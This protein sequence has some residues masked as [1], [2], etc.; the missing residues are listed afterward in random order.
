MPIWAE[1]QELTNWGKNPDGKKNKDLLFW[2][3]ARRHY[4]AKK[5]ILNPIEDSNNKNENEM[6]LKIFPKNSSKWCIVLQT[7]SLYYCHI[8]P[9]SL[10]L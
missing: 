9:Q 4:L 2:N 7:E 1:G 5:F 8:L 3:S 10:Y 6:F